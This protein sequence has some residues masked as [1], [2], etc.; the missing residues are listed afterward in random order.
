MDLSEVFCVA[1]SGV[2]QDTFLWNS[3]GMHTC[4]V[5]F[6][7][8]ANHW[9]EGILYFKGHLLYKPILHRIR[10]DLPRPTV[11]SLTVEDPEESPPIDIGTGGSIS[12]GGKWRRRIGI[13]EKSSNRLC[14]FPLESTVPILHIYRIDPALQGIDLVALAASIRVANSPHKTDLFQWKIPLE[15]IDR[16]SG[17]LL[18]EST[19]P[20]AY[21]YS[22]RGPP[23]H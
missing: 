16:G 1:D 20:V 6:S 21:I 19:A 17:I 11:E 8:I 18:E 3:M 7:N 9:L 12:T 13:E 15:T 5:W 22:N 23:R 4:S 14:G 2:L 10:I